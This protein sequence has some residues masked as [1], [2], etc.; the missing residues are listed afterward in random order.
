[1]SAPAELSVDDARDLV[2]R[3][4]EVV[5]A[6]R[7]LAQPRKG[8]SKK[9]RDKIG[10]R[11]GWICRIC[12]EPV[13]PELT[14]RQRTPQEARDHAQHLAQYTAHDLK[15]VIAWVGQDGGRAH[16]A[17]R[18]FW[19]ATSANE[20]SEETLRSYSRAFY[21]AVLPVMR[22]RTEYNS[23]TASVEH[24]HPVSVGGGNETDNLAIAHRGCN[25]ASNPSADNADLLDAPRHAAE[26]LVRLTRGST[27]GRAQADRLNRVCA[28]LAGCGV[29]VSDRSDLVAQFPAALAAV[30]TA[31][32]DMW[33]ARRE[34]RIHLLRLRWEASRL[35]ASDE[36]ARLWTLSREYEKVPWRGHTAQW[37]LARRAE[38]PDLSPDFIE[39]MS[40]W[41][42]DL[43]AEDDVTE[44]PGDPGLRS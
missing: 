13:D 26:F 20:T 44:R 4:V 10:R 12:G 31:F 25:T 42:F 8:V 40:G 5:K 28:A 21:D 29:E 16:S 7:A 22:A 32:A 41:G 14:Y 15:A 24:L 30:H 37:W 43:D 34:C 36:R 35:G 27:N 39:L 38:L 2:D 9:Q 23:R 11:D 17:A 6:L 19:E 18:W 33:A 1:V 3:S